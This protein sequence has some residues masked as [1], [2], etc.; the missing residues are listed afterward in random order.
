MAGVRAQ[1]SPDDPHERAD[2][3]ERKAAEAP[4]RVGLGCEDIIKELVAAVY[5]RLVVDD[6][7]ALRR[8]KRERVRSF[9]K[10]LK[11][12]SINIVCDYFRELHQLAPSF[13]TRGAWER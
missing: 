1:I 4:I 2:A 3:F 12:I 6:S 13:Q 11:L 9:Q 7:D 10:Y 8:F 5:F